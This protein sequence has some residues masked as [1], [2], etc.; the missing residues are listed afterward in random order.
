[1]SKRLR[2]ELGLRATTVDQVLFFVLRSVYVTTRPKETGQTWHY[3]WMKKTNRNHGHRFLAEAIS[4][5][6]WLYNRFSLSFRDVQDL[7]AH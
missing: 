3:D 7:M 5:A 4:T 2:L 6:V 1:M